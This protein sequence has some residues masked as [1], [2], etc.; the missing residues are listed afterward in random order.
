MDEGNDLIFFVLFALFT[1]KVP[2]ALYRLMLIFDLNW[3]LDTLGGKVVN[4]DDC[5]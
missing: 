4:F 3:T 5:L 2:A 1:L